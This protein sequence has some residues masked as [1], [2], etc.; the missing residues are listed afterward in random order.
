[1]NANEKN[2]QLTTPISSSTPTA[3]NHLIH[4]IKVNASASSPNDT[5]APSKECNKNIVHFMSTAVVPIAC[6]MD[7][8]SYWT[9]RNLAFCPNWR[10]VHKA[11]KH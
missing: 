7:E 11:L 6:A 5:S 9:F 3:N 1:M 8:G 10:G 4:C 2:T